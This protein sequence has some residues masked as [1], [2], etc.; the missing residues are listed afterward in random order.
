MVPSMRDGGRNI[1]LNCKNC[2]KNARK[3]NQYNFDVRKTC[4]NIQAVF[5][6]KK[7]NNQNMRLHYCSYTSIL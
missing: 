3:L 4:D 6:K 2:I 7:R 1:V 5:I